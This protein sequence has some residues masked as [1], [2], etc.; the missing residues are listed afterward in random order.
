LCSMNIHNKLLLNTFCNS[1][2]PA[3]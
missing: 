1:L 3:L 2:H